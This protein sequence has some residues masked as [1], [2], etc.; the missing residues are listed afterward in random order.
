MNPS[1][2]I[3]GPRSI[4]RRQQ[5]VIASLCIQQ[6]NRY[7]MIYIPQYATEDLALYND[8][9]SQQTTNFNYLVLTHENPWKLLDFQFCWSIIY[10]LSIAVVSREDLVEQRKF[11]N[12]S[13]IIDPVFSGGYLC[14]PLMKVRSLQSP[15]ENPEDCYVES[16][17]GGIFFRKSFLS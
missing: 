9:N 4:H 12:P 1:A 8:I 10:N 13:G 11:L 5:L 17:F 3:F 15:T 14:P 16:F 6:C 2:V 7:Y